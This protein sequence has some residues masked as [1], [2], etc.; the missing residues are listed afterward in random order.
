MVRK[1]ALLIGVVLAIAAT[2]SPSIRATAD[3]TGPCSRIQQLAGQCTTSGS[4]D[5][6]GVTVTGTINRG[7]D[8]SGSGSSAGGG[9]GHTL[10]DAELRALLDQICVGD[11]HCDARNNASL[12]PLILQG[13][14]AAAGAADPAAAI[15]ITDLARFLPA[16]TALHAEPNGWAVVGVPANL[17]VD[18]AAVTVDGTLLGDT[19]E[20]RFT[21]Q[22][23]R[24]D[25]G[26]GSTRTATSAG[27]SWAALGQEEL[28]ATP[29]SHV[30][31]ARG[32]RRAMV[33]VVYSAEYRFAGGPWIAVAGAVSGT[34]PPQRVLVVVERTALTTLG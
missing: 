4:S 10:T 12:N 1:S 11:G 18:V 6:S 23:Y 31:T 28:T 33:T 16:S 32:D 7:H 5:G 25:Y 19:A 3:S 29:T 2:L 14:A 20:V 13:D 30:Y 26:D 21:P 34:T 17:W 22:A 9:S 8:G 15:T 24:F 27:A